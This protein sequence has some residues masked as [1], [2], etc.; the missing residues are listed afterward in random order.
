MKGH[1]ENPAPRPLENGPLG[2]YWFLTFQ[3][4][5]EFHAIVKEC[6]QSVNP[7]Q[8]AAT[9][10]DGLHLTLDRIARPHKITQ[11]SL[12]LVVDASRQA[13]RDLMPFTIPITCLN[14]IRGA[15][16]FIVNPPTPILELRDTLRKATLSTFPYAC[17]RETNSSPHITIAYP[18]YEDMADAAGA[19]AASANH[20]VA[21]IEVSAATLV[22]LTVRNN[23]YE[24]DAVE[25]IPLGDRS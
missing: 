1:P 11:E 2:H 9:P 16:C 17:I 6:Q 12:D 20:G 23:M 14:N 7:D 4:C 5:I 25:R 13:C 24:W 21:E 19:I 15:V 18:K 22:S 10:I 8:F 3:N